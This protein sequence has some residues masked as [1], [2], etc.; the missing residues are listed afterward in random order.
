MFLQVELLNVL[1]CSTERSRFYEE[2]FEIS[3][4]V[5]IV[6]FNGTLFDKAIIS[7]NY[8]FQNIIPG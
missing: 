5:V 6:T 2:S 1:L 3:V 8:R 7:D 4:D